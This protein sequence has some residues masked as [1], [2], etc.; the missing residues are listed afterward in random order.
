MV[1]SVRCR[2]KW[3]KHRT[4][5]AYRP[6]RAGVQQAAKM[7]AG[8]AIINRNSAT[9]E[10]ML[11]RFFDAFSG[12][13]DCFPVSFVLFANA[14]TGPFR[15]F[16]VRF[17]IPNFKEKSDGKVFDRLAVGYPCHRFSDYL[18]LVLVLIYCFQ[19]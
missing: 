7:L 10:A 18:F 19:K 15:N 12:R 14:Q 11:R 1:S 16:I 2:T 5:V 17:S 9:P 13:R 6:Q 4:D 3:T 8:R